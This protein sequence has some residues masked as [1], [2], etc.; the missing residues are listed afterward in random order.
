[1]SNGAVILTFGVVST[2]ASIDA[3]NLLKPVSARVTLRI[4]GAM[5]AN[6][7]RKYF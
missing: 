7:Y 1:M 5:T 2:D 4:I 6:V 3:D